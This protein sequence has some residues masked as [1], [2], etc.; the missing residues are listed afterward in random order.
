[1]DFVAL[2]TAGGVLAGVGG[3]AAAL[4]AVASRV[5]AVQVD[6]RITAITAVLPGANCGGCG[7]PGC[8]GY[9]SAIVN[10]GVDP[11]LCAPAGADAA[12]K[13]GAIMGVEV[14]DREKV[15]ARIRCGGGHDKCRPRFEYRGLKTCKGAVMLNEGGAKSCP[16]GCEGLGDCV[17]V[18]V[19]DAIHM[20]ADGIPVVDMEKCTG[21]GKCVT[22][23]PKDVI[24]LQAC[25][26]PVAINCNSQ[27]KGKEVKNVCEVGCI[28]C[29]ACVKACPWEAI[30]MRGNIPVIDY[31]KCHACG[32]CVESCKPGS[33]VILRAID[34]TAKQEGQKII[35]DRKAAAAAAKAAAAAAAAKPA[36]VQE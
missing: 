2:V 30:S 16:Y 10:K 35:A 22:A 32:L 15:I 18:C 24:E 36:S 26:G 14:P 12:R 5:F 13:I 19:F 4:L 8:S 11:S 31:S 21:C 28:T 27:W 7:F 29:L 6:E 17:D 23:C 33:I 20:G 34:E 25:K 3:A 9:A 1:M